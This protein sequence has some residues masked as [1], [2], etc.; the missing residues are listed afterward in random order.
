MLHADEPRVHL[1][2]RVR[3]KQPE[4]SG[5]ATIS[6]GSELVLVPVTVLDGRGA[7]V[8]GLGRESFRIYE[9]GV[10]QTIRTFTQEE[11]P[12]SIGIVFD[13]SR[14]MTAKIGEAR[15]AVARLFEQAV[16]GDEYHLVEFNDSPRL[17]CE[18][19]RDIETVRNALDR[20]IPRGWTALFDGVLLSAQSMRRASNER[21]AL[22]VLSDGED[23]F[24]RYDEG[25]LN[26][27]LNEAGVVIYSIG[28]TSG[29]LFGHQTRHL[30]RMSTR[31]GGWCYTV[32]KIEELG[33]T[34]RAISDAIRSQYSVGYMPA[35]PGR[36]GKFRRIRIQVDAKDHPEWNFSW[37][38]GY[39]APLRQ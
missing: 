1:E 15:E 11:L 5:R 2:P 35:N 39:Y 17:L 32:T 29:G 10:E 31:T 23:N 21:R 27:Y 25:D 26:S 7:P 37:R 38:N 34:I 4:S 16:P 33:E 20:V 9:E 14:S 22:V 3:N 30:R 6:I 24:S 18:L 28:L 19:T 13:A 8:R 12:V 36:D